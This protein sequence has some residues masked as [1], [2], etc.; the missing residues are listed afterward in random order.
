MTEIEPA[1]FADDIGFAR[2]D[3]IVEVNHEAVSSV[4]EY[5]QVASRLKPGQSVVFKVMRRT[6]SERVLTIFL[7]GVIPAEAQ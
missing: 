6:D 7:S 4:S 2:G 1:S 3:L 5:R